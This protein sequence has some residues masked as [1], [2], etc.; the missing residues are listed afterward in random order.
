MP[1][2]QRLRRKVTHLFLLISLRTNGSQKQ[3]F[4]HILFDHFYDQNILTNY[5]FIR[6]TEIWLEDTSVHNKDFKKY[7]KFTLRI[8]NNYLIEGTSLLVSYDGDSFVLSRNLSLIQLDPNLLGTVIY[9]NRIIKYKLLS[10]QEKTDHA[11]IYPKLNRDIERALRIETGRNFS[12]NKYKKYYDLIHQFYNNY[13]KG[14]VISGQIKI[15]E[16]GFYR[17]YEEKIEQTSEDSNLLLFGNNQKNFIPYTGLKEYGPLQAPPTNKLVKFFFIFHE[18]DKELANKIYSYLKKGYKSFAGLESFVEIKF[19][20]DTTKTIRFSEN[21]PITE[22]K[23]AIQRTQFDTNITYV[24]LYI[25]RIKRDTEDEE[26]EVVYYKLKELLLSHNISSQVI[27]KDNIDNPSFNFFLPNIAI[28]LLAKL[29]GKPWRLYRPIKNDLVIGIGADR[30]PVVKSQFI[31]TA[32]CF[33]NDGSFKG[34]NAYERANTSALAN[35]IKKSVEQY[36]SR[37]RGV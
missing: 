28:A 24:A 9:Q 7:T 15:F 19:D 36:I 30:S 22:I 23:S 31:G 27:F 35:S 11:N 26:E 20:I 34:F 4:N 29:G 5:N 6:D 37:K 21:N 13:L 1:G 18:E 10:E 2:G 8:D 3:Y 16:S 25:S 14:A 33:R 12:E 17:P 32:F